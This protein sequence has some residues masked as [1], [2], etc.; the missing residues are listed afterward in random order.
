MPLELPLNYE[1]LGNE[2]LTSHTS[3]KVIVLVLE[4]C[5]II[6]IKINK[7]D[8]KKQHNYTLLTL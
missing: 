1:M 5:N 7:G 4:V 6:Q 2:M 8:C 3:P